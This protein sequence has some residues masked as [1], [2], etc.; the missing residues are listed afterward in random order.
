MGRMAAA[1]PRARS[2]ASCAAAR[3]LAPCLCACLVAATG[4]AR[5]AQWPFDDTLKL[6]LDAKEV[7][8]GEAHY[9]QLTASAQVPA[10][11]VEQWTDEVAAQAGDAVVGGA[12][13]GYRVWIRIT[14]GGQPLE[15]AREV[16]GTGPL[17][18]WLGVCPC[19]LGDRI[20]FKRCAATQ[21][22]VLHPCQG[23][24]AA[25]QVMWWVDCKEVAQEHLRLPDQQPVAAGPPGAQPPLPALPAPR[26]P[27]AAAKPAAAPAPPG[28]IR[29]AVLCRHLDPHGQPVDP[30]TKFPADV[31]AVLLVISHDFPP[32]VHGD[33]H[34]TL[35]RD[36]QA[37]KRHEVEVAGKGRFLI[38]YRPREGTSFTPGKW[39]VRIETD[40]KLDRELTFTVGE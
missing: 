36:G 40:G 20:V 16:P 1:L 25:Y 27:P 19:Y 22:S 32:A 24:A 21:V 10:E 8:V 15:P 28:P 39:C 30:T 3:S 37:R 23:P 5:A 4:G 29:D 18:D 31:E 17:A 38:E 14:R 11:M 9:I 35:L 7:R 6:A 26:A 34:V 12:A 13:R 2:R 33:I